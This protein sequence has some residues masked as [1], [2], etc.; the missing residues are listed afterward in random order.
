MM[1]SVS[2]AGRDRRIFFRPRSRRPTYGA[3][4]GRVTRRKPCASST[5][6]MPRPSA[7]QSAWRRVSASATTSG[8]ASQAS[9]SW[10][11][12]S[13]SAAENK[14]ASITGTSSSASIGSSLDFV[15][16]GRLLGR[17]VLGRGELDLAEVRRLDGDQAVELEQLEQ[18]QERDDHLEPAPALG[19]QRLEGQPAGDEHAAV[20][21][22][23]LLLDVVGLALELEHGARRQP[24]EHAVE[25]VEQVEQGGRGERQGP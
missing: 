8:S 14:S 21:A 11:A 12:V 19:E 13:G 2:S 25:R 18:G 7:S 3:K 17:L 24:G 10:V 6:R 5:R 15:S 16:R 1:A 9:A 4:S 23:D 20:D 22:G